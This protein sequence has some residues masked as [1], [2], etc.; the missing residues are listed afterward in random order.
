MTS[1][2][3]RTWPFTAQRWPVETRCRWLRQPILK[4]RPARAQVR[5]PQRPSSQLV[6]VSS[7][8]IQESFVPELAVLRLSDPVAFIGENEQLGG[9]GLALQGREELQ[10]L[11]VGNAIIHFT[12]NH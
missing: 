7:Q 11:R 12:S 5:W 3:R 9:H 1:F 8:P 6:Q 4:F 2:A 10:R